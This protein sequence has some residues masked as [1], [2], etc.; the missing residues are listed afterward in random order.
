MSKKG[1]LTVA[2][3]AGGD[4][5]ASEEFL[6]GRLVERAVARLTGI[7]D[8][9]IVTTDAAGMEALEGIAECGMEVRLVVDET[10]EGSGEDVAEC[11][12]T[13]DCGGERGSGKLGGLRTAL[14]ATS[15]DFVAII[16][17]DM[18][19]PSSS[20]IGFELALAKKTGADLVVPHTR[21]GLE[22]FCAVYR[23]E[24]CLAAVDEALAQGAQRCTT[25]A[26]RV[27][28]VEFNE[29]QALEVDPRG[30][31]FASLSGTRAIRRL[32]SRIAEGRMRQKGEFTDEKSAA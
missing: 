31:C 28:T 6:G 10:P 21:H 32:E 3:Q 4:A 27:K 17:G 30:G 24:T 22:P 1:N 18:P 20:V 15:C 14:A 5:P 19:F 13:G 23:R 9:L 7:A 26:K 8:E 25:L 12:S 16:A 29:R 11:R 2:I